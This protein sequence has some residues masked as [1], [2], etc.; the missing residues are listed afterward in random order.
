MKKLKVV[1][2]FAFLLPFFLFIFQAYF[3]RIGAFGCFDDCFNY[4]AGYFILKGKTL[5]AEIFFTHQPLMAILSS[6]IQRL[7]QPQSIYQLVAFHRI[8]ILLF[9]FLMDIFLIIRFRGAGLGFVVF[10]E[11]T[12][13]YLFG[14]RFLGE[15]VIVYPLVY[16]FGLFWQ[17][18]QG[19]KLRLVE[20]L[21]AAGFAWLIVFTREA[22]IP[23]ALFLFLALIWQT[24]SSKRLAP[25]GAFIFLTLAI[26]LCLPLKD[27]LFNVVWANFSNLG[28]E[29][30]N[31]NLLGVGLLKIFAYPFYI[32]LG[33]PQNYFKIILVGLSS[34]F[35]LLAGFWAIKLRK[36]GLILMVFLTLGLANIRLVEPGKVFY[37]A[38]HMAPWYGLFIFI[39]CLLLAGVVKKKPKIVFCS[40]LVILLAT[41][42]Y[43]FVSPQWFVKE[44]SNKDSEFTTSYGHDFVHGEVVKLLASPSDTLFLDGWDDLIYWQ[45]D[46]PSAYKY[47]WYTSDM[48]FYPIYSLAR[49]EMFQK[50]PPDFYYGNCAK[51][52]PQYLLPT[53]RAKDYL[54]LYFAGEPTCLYVN[55]TKLAIIDQGRWAKVKKLGFYLP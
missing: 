34:V 39:I 37:G 30:S 9:A 54:A 51:N 1:F 55:R 11:A 19:K 52:L 50:Y 22:F 23:V 5:Y 48:P 40:G 17:Q 38:F 47:A 44:K 45:A 29:V 16:L 7:T 4:V 28:S 53:Y 6:F 20:L 36:R 14:D 10:Y 31:T 15:A 35:L 41:L 43:L 27:Y 2:L 49:E 32:F 26:F 12:K 24:P 8:A 21:V 33:G 25:A 46:L 42:A 3:Q 13:F 18:A